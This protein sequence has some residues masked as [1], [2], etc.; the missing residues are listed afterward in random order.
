[1]D[2][3]STW[4][5]LL[6]SVGIEGGACNPAS[7]PGRGIGVVPDEAACEPFDDLRSQ[8]RHDQIHGDGSEG[9]DVGAVTAERA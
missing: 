1:M 6:G 7:N 5:G 8:R 9:V 3:E 4:G 2:D